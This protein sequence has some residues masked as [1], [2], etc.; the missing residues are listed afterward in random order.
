M[1]KIILI[2]IWLAG[3]IAFGF[4]TIFFAAAMVIFHKYAISAFLVALFNVFGAIYSYRFLREELG[5]PKVIQNRS[6]W[7][8]DE[9]QK[10][11]SKIWE[12]Q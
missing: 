12:R 11:I 5:G 8:T 4:F 10:V 1:K 7:I 3:V 9:L 2:T 6:P